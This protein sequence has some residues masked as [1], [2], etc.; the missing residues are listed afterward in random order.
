M[1]G[2]LLSDILIHGEDSLNRFREESKSQDSFGFEA[3]KAP[4]IRDTF[5]HLKFSELTAERAARRF[6]ALYGSNTRPRALFNL[7]AKG[8]D[9]SLSKFED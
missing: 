8:S 9:P 2:E 4:M 5:G 1:G 3:S 6:N 7:S